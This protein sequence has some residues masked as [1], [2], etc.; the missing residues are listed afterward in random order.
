M[1]GLLHEDMFHVQ[2]ILKSAI[3]GSL[4]RAYCLQSRPGHPDVVRQ[5]VRLC[6]CWKWWQDDRMPI[7]QEDW[8]RQDE[9]G[10]DR[11]DQVTEWLSDW[12]TEWPSDRLT[13][14]PS[15]RVTKWP[16][17]QLTGWQ[18]DRK[19]CR[20]LTVWYI[21][22]CNVVQI[23]PDSKLAIGIGHLW[24]CAGFMVAQIWAIN[25]SKNF[26]L[27][28]YSGDNKKSICYAKCSFKLI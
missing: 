23:Y 1:T 25:F 13:E 9:T 20:R 14:W 5:L 28:Q 27:H 2:C 16:I 21:L 12:V 4:P 24:S 22:M 10:W 17:D 15:D 3:F 26:E 18:D 19:L 8:M 6:Q 7:C 11:C